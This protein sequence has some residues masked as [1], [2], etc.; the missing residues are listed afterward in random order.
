MMSKWVLSGKCPKYHVARGG[1]IGYRNAGAYEGTNDRR[2]SVSNA[3]GVSEWIH[4]RIMVTKRKRAGHDA[5]L[6]MTKVNNN[7]AL[8]KRK[9]DDESYTAEEGKEWN[10]ETDRGI[11]IL[12]IQV[13]LN[14]SY[15]SPGGS[16]ADPLHARE[17]YTAF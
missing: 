9:G 6:G 10:A 15:S 16:S 17:S 11:Q 14:R 1:F 13:V 12:G 8:W 3:P 7:A 5:S 4:P 2:A